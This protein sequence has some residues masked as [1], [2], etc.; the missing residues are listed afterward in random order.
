MIDLKSHYSI[1]KAF[2]SPETI[3]EKVK[4]LGLNYAG[5]T[6]YHSVSGCVSFVKACKEAGI[7]PILGSTLSLKE[8][9][10]LIVLCKNLQGWKDLIKII[11]LSYSRYYDKIN[12]T[13]YFPLEELCKYEN[14]IFVAGFLEDVIS[15]RIFG[16]TVSHLSKEEL[17][18][19]VELDPISQIK[20]LNSQ[21]PNLYLC[22]SRNSSTYVDW[23]NQVARDSGLPNIILGNSHYPNKEDHE[24]FRVLLCASLKTTKERY[25]KVCLEQ[26]QD[27][28]K[29]DENTWE[30]SLDGFSQE[31]LDKTQ[32]LADSIESYEILSSPRLPKYNCPNNL[33]PIE[34]LK[35][36][37]REGWKKLLIPSGKLKEKQQEYLERIKYELG[38]IEECG[39]AS[40][41][42]IM[43]DIMKWNKEQGWLNSPGRGSAG[44]CLISYLTGIIKID[45]VEYGLLFSRFFSASRKG[46]LPDIDSDFPASKR[47]FV[48]DYIRQK[49]GEDR[50]CHMV[51]FSEFKGASAIKEVLR[52]YDV[53]SFDVMNEITKAIPEEGK[54]ADQME[55]LGEDSILGFTL[56]Y[57]PDK[58]KDW[59]TYENEKLTGDYAKWFDLAIRLEGTI[60]GTGKHASAIVVFEEP[61]SNVCPMI[62]DKSS[63]HSLAGVD[64]KAAENL[65]LV[66]LDCLGL[67]TLD[68]L[69]TTQ[70]LI[71]SRKA[72]YASCSKC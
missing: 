37:C 56:K 62:S 54:I 72:Y 41:F 33:E 52:V 45:P 5:L 39:L 21:L 38:V 68:L 11:S 31:E 14:F 61:L 57:Q 29:F 6:D 50:V 34:Y 65:G 1:K 40:Y 24:V 18:E 27:L 43:A 71:K 22:V 23:W 3:V 19:S 59:V 46:S 58:L 55:A 51:T 64:M 42:L 44:G 12:S 70:D 26:A 16:K 17:L 60:Q 10:K 49:Y 28:V 15:H 48:I 32:K 20:S 36:L 35:E 67:S 66:K 30:I 9:G 13:P 2:G 7:K 63:E 4:S 47:Q 8:G 25:K 69:M 53:C